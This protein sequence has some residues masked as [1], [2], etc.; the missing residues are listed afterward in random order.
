MKKINS[1]QFNYMVGNILA[2]YSKYI[3]IPENEIM[4]KINEFNKQLENQIK[5]EK[6]VQHSKNDSDTEKSV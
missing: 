4:N 6:S 2:L 1:D 5:N 3:G